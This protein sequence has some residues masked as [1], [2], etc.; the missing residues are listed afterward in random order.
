FAR[1]GEPKIDEA[2]R[3]DKLTERMAV[4]HPVVHFAAAAKSAELQQLVFASQQA[5][6]QPLAPIAAQQLPASLPE[7]EADIPVCRASP[8]VANHRAVGA[9]PGPGDVVRAGLGKIV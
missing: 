7:C 9:Q 4:V 8:E 2:G 6:N 5:A 3:R 1:L